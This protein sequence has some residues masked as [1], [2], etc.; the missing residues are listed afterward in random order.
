MPDEAK[1]SLR[2]RWR[3]IVPAPLRH[4]ILIFLV[5]IVVEYLVVPELIGASR[6]IHYLERLN[7]GW[8]VAGVG[9]EAFSLFAYALLTWTVLPGHRPRVSRVFRI[10]LATTAVAHTVPGGSAASAGLGYRLLTGEGVSG[11][12]AGF[13]MATQ[14]IGSAVVLNVMLWLALVISI[15]IAGFH[16]IYVVVALL[17]MIA[18]GFFA[19]LIYFLTRGEDPAIRLVRRVGVAIPRVRPDRFEATFRHIAESLRTLTTNRDRLRAALG[20]AA[21]NW[22]LDAA[23]LWSFLAALGRYVNPIELFAAYGIANVLA[24]IP[25]TP[26]GLGFV[27]ASLPLLLASFGVTKNVA[28]LS[29]LGWRIVN[30]WLPIPVGAVSYLSLKLH[31]GEGWRASRRALAELTVRLPPPEPPPAT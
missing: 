28:L 31:R 13:T 19:V 26:G 4:G 10:D 29:V 23:A 15:P 6:N 25:I 5:V 20:W 17:G 24:A 14:G 12:D 22:L 8:L 7:V 3:A 30:F 21:T 2:S 16:T 9:F 11:T 27:E 1:T 18:L